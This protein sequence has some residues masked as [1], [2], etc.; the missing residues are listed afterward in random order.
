MKST[1]AEKLPS[2]ARV[3]PQPKSYLLE[4]KD[5]ARLPLPLLV[6]LVM[7]M[8]GADDRLISEEETHQQLVAVRQDPL[9][10]EY[11]HLLVHATCQY[12]IA[13]RGNVKGVYPTFN[14]DFIFAPLLETASKARLEANK[15]NLLYRGEGSAQDLLCILGWYD[16]QLSEYPFLTLTTKGRLLDHVYK[17]ALSDRKL[18]EANRDTFYSRLT[19]Q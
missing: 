14:E 8:H 16:H 3:L 12:A 1:E 5:N 9:A 6:N 7:F 18:L 15:L 17:L 11:Y 10:N 13:N 19:T 4:K 2:I